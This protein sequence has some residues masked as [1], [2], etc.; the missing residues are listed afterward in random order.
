MALRN[1]VV[2]GGGLVGSAVACAIGA[3]NGGAGCGRVTL[4]DHATSAIP[5][6]KLTHFRCDS[7]LQ[8]L[9]HAVFHPIPPTTFLWQCAPRLTHSQPSSITATLYML[10]RIVV[11]VRPQLSA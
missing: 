7:T 2:V 11:H 8:L 6:P 3:V 10:E 1:T 4:L 5:A 9:W